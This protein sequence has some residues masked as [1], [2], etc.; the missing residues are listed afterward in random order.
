VA[1]VSPCGK[2]AIDLMQSG[3]D[4]NGFIAPG[5]GQVNRST[6]GQRAS[7]SLIHYVPGLALAREMVVR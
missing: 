4:D 1:A 5:K 3:I 6:T 7:G 2:W